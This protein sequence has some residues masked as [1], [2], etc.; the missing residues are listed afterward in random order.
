MSIW[1]VELPP[2][3]FLNQAQH[4]VDYSTLQFRVLRDSVSDK[5]SQ[6]LPRLDS[7]PGVI[8]YPCNHLSSTY[9]SFRDGVGEDNTACESLNR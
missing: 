8:I 1:S 9:R 5:S 4:R 6:N 7:T 2:I 3:E